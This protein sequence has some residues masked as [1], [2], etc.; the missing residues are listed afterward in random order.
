MLDQTSRKAL[1]VG[2]E[3]EEAAESVAGW[4]VAGWKVEREVETVEGAGVVGLALENL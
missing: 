3:T 4:E 1:G 2:G